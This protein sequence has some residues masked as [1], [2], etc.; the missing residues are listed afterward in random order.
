VQR[1]PVNHRIKPAVR[2][3]QLFDRRDRFVTTV[4]VP[5]I[6]PEAEV[7]KYGDLLYVRVSG[8]QYR[9]AKVWIARDFR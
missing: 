1:S 4:G 2:E 6:G 8:L 7:V 3:I 9:E 5:P